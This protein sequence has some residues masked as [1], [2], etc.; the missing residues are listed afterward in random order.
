M[1]NE[2]LLDRTLDID[3]LADYLRS[4]DA[5]D[6]VMVIDACNAAGSVERGDSPGEQPTAARAADVRYAA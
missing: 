2:E 5:R 4:V 1:V 3:E 6:F